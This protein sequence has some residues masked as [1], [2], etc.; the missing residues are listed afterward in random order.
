MSESS[1]HPRAEL[2]RRLMPIACATLAAL[3]CL[4]PATAASSAEPVA[5]LELAVIPNPT[6]FSATHTSACEAEASEPVPRVCDGF[7]VTA[8]SSGAV[9]ASGQITITDQLPVGLLI[10]S[11]QVQ[12]DRI[13]PG[14]AGA[15]SEGAEESLY[16]SGSPTQ[17]GKT[18]GVSCKATGQTF[19]C[20]FSGSL[21]VDQ[22]LQLRLPVFTQAGAASGEINTATLGG[23]AAP[24]SIVE[25]PISVDSP[26]PFG[27]SSLATSLSDAAGEPL[28]Q[29]GAHPYEYTTRFS[30]ASVTQLSPESQLIATSVEDLRDAAVDLPPGLVCSAQAAPKCTQI[31]LTTLAGCPPGS[32]VGYIRTEPEALA[33]VNSGLY[34]I[35]PE[36]GVAAEFGFSDVLNNVHF[37]YAGVVPGP[38]GYVVRATTPETPQIALSSV[39]ATFYG[40]PSARDGAGEVL[41]P[42]FSMPA[43]CSGAPLTSSIHIDSWQNP[44][45]LN[46]DGS[47]DLADPRWASA[48]TTTPAV[49]GCEELH[50]EPSIE[51]V[52]STQKADSPTGLDVNLKVPQTEGGEELATP[53]LKKA[54]VTLPEGVS[55]NPSSANG[56]GACSLAQVGISASGRPDAAQPT[57]P[58]DSKIGTV[59]LET[60]V[61][62][63]ILQGQIYVARQ[64]ENPF[65]S[66]LALYIVVDDPTTGVL[67]KLAGRV[68]TDETTGQLTT[69][70]DNSPQLP[71][72][73]LRTHFF[74]G[75]RAALRTPA[76]CSTAATT[77]ELTPWSAPQSGPAA[78]PSAPFTVSA[79]ANGGSCAT[80]P[81]AEPNHP[82]FSAGSTDPL[83]GA[84]APFVV[85]GAR[86]DGD[87]PITRVNV[88]LPKG[89][90]GKLAG[91]PYCPESA[92]SLAH[93]REHL[94][95]GQE[96]VN[97]P[98]C[99]A[100]SEVGVV[101]VGAGAGPEP[102]YVTGHAYLAGPYNGG[103]LSIVII[104]P[105]LAGPFDLGTVVVRTALQLNLETAQISAVSD[106]IPTI[107]HGIPLDLRSISLEMSRHEF[108]LNPTN[109]EKQS[110]LAE[111]LGQ[112]GSTAKLSDPFQV[113]G[114]KNLAFKPKLAISLKGSTKRAG[115]PALKATVTYPK[116]AGYAN[117]AYAQVALP[118]TEFLDQ[119]NL[120]KVCTQ[121]QLKSDSCPKSSVYGTA[122]A[123][124]PLLEKPLEGPVYLGVG[125]GYKLPALVADLNGQIRILLHGKVDTD[126]ENGIRNT[127][128][129]VP[130]APV[131]RFVLEMK[132]GP[133]YGLLEN[134]AGVCARPQKA[135]VKF[136]AQNGTVKEYRQKI[137]NGCGKSAKGKKSGKG[138]KSH[139][140]SHKSSGKGHRK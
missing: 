89:M 105:A 16:H 100:A 13:Y 107:L 80:S 111:A 58:E 66:L 79:A 85:R 60:P 50:F 96:E 87:Q 136:I 1:R 77:T 74:S 106:P 35:A 97:S 83:A 3:A 131:S 137:Q 138:K 5:H 52:P 47:P 45:P 39:V 11:A 71:F 93:S 134:T 22:A 114:C 63:G 113:V 78:T 49:T 8:Y 7:R 51:A 140:K 73:E 127:F 117:I 62:P 102:Y 95:G 130:D 48:T 99:P 129:V 30:P 2:R 72:S 40:N 90:V 116:G 12:L 135:A 82:S 128:E 57:C 86:A 54:V 94:G 120:D 103:P 37:I 125:Y 104:S 10:D 122:K 70:V 108:T 18:L 119:G 20:K 41:P 17:K 32:K 64:T 67:V 29:A 34:N 112:F 28:I 124:S 121:P 88:T 44:G 123:W 25:T 118:G 6:S 61:L 59:E 81:G 68:V 27:V 69:V 38:E 126:S 31:Q 133:R 55:V 98:S 92:I 19:S 36:H 15:S 76:I 109:C 56:L 65:G 21:A 33:V 9:G 4:V 139:G 115:H 53:P 43:D 132:G 101:H 91:I 84:Y 42:M 14:A 24:G 46:A 75:N 26:T 110:V 23:T